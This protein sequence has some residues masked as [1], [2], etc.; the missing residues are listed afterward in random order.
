MNNHQT[1]SKNLAQRFAHWLRLLFVPHRHNDYRP[2]LIR[3]YGLVIILV[4]ILALQSTWFIF[5]DGQTLSDKSDITTSRLL[6]ETNAERDRNSLPALNLNDNLAT[7]ARD[8]AEN[9]LEVGYWSHNAPDGT[10]PWHW[11]ESTGYLYADA[12]ENL[13]RGFNTTD[14]IMQAWMESPTHRANVLSKDYTEVG[15][16]AVSGKIDGKD[17]VLVV[18]MYARPLGVPIAGVLANTNAS[19][20]ETDTSLWVRFKRG[21]NNLTPS[22]MITL[23]LLGITTCVAMLAHAYRSKLPKHLR[24]SWYRH[25]AIYKIAIFIIIA[26]SAILSYGNGAI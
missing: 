25:H 1:Q 5:F 6:D 14:S 2:H 15:F 9:M 26:V 3:R 20:T 18:A 11:I 8:K 10:T 24:E 23:I 4:L 19:E 21:M 16:A 13:A 22:L 17:G 7:A 12:G